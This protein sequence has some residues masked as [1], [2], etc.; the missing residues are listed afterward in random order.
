MTASRPPL[1]VDRRRSIHGFPVRLAI[2]AVVLLVVAGL[3]V[4]LASVTPPHAAV[5]P[6]PPLRAASNSTPL[7][8][9]ATVTPTF[10]PAPLT[11]QFSAVPAGGTAPYRVGIDFGDGSS[12]LVLNNSGNGSADQVN[13]TYARAGNY[14]ADL[15][16]NDS[17]GG[18]N[19]TTLTVSA[20]GGSTG[21]NNSSRV[22]ILA[23]PSSGSA[24][25]N[26]TLTAQFTGNATAV[27]WT[28]GD[29]ATGTG[30][31]AGH[32]YT[33]PG[34][35]RVGVQVSGLVTG[36]VVGANATVLVTNRSTTGSGNSSG[37][38]ANATVTPTSGGAPLWVNF[39][40]APYGGTSP[41]AVLWS[42][43]DGTYIGPAS[44]PG[45]PQVYSVVH[46]YSAVGTYYP[47]IIVNDSAGHRTT[48]GFT[49][50]VSAGNGTPQLTVAAAPATG[51]APL[52]VTLWAN[53]SGNATPT[54]YRW[55]FGD[56]G[57]GTGTPITHV[58]AAAGAY[59][60]VVWVSGVL[61][62]G[63]LVGNTT[64][65]VASGSGPGTGNGSLQI[66]LSATPTSGSAP[67]N[68][69]VVANVTGGTAPYQ[70]SYCQYIGNGSCNLTGFASNVSA[71]SPVR[72]SL[73]ENVSGTVTVLVRAVDASLNSSLATVGI[74][75][76][77]GGPLAARIALNA[78]AGPEPLIVG[79]NAS[80]SGGTAPY[81]IQWFFGDG[82]VGSSL[83]GGV[84][85]HT[86][87][88]GHYWP[89]LRVTDS[90]GHGLVRAAPHDIVVTTNGTVGCALPLASSPPGGLMTVL[91]GLPVSVLLAVVAAGGLGAGL[92]VSAVG[93]HRLQRRLE[94]A[95]GETLA[96]TMEGP[97][98][99]PT[100]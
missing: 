62:N 19:S 80:I 12:S 5:A 74:D 92:A 34:S 79:L 68:V 51:G 11:V 98:R 10:G 26:V 31:P 87:E 75:V 96:L 84:V 22:S 9:I 72:L 95:E 21:G 46:A 7:S 83:S 99:P 61:P 23:S 27:N 81:T 70:L 56:G 8:L 43:G 2:S 93:Y 39:T 58:Y 18:S 36:R 40:A 63:S 35:F 90:A 6:P 42:F 86:Y 49:V 28:F 25:L 3:T 66:G 38:Q 71:G 30:N 82:S 97:L 64:I 78:T 32:T 55:L 59:R 45:S 57:N 65:T 4:V 100:G 88:A 52:T 44:I 37:L 77:G 16:V 67:L 94:R 53:V 47:S 1:A 91:S 73:T 76:G 89:V 24:P 69:T 29:G 60:A 85:S 17:V 41:Y 54:G 13:H 48:Q 15:W 20:T 50:V 33:S 14:T